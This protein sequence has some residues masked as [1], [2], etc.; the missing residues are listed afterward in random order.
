M[1][2][3]MSILM[4]SSPVPRASGIQSVERAMAALKLFGD[5]EP[6]LGVTELARRL[7]L[8]KSTTSRLMSTLETGGFVQQDRRSGRYR[9]GL[10][11]ATLA[12]RA[13]NQYDLRDVAR[14]ALTN[15]ATETGETCNL[16]VRDGDAAV[17]IEQALSPN[18]V[19]HLGWIG[20]RLP[21]HC[22]AAGKPF[23]AFASRN[24]TEHLLSRPLPAYTART[25]TDVGLMWQEIERIRTEGFA[26]AIEE[27]EPELT[28]AGA[29]VRDYRG[30]VIATV[31]VSGPSFRLNAERLREIA[32]K[33]RITADALSASL[34]YRTGTGPATL[35]TVQGKTAHARVVRR[36]VE[37]GPTSTERAD[38]IYASDVM[39]SDRRSNGIP[40]S[41]VVPAQV[42]P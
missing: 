27:F 26:L 3:G 15:L 22:S 24:E 4:D 31:T 28:A 12:S 13:L 7:S 1:R 39:R 11:L 17:N 41:D 8:H 36:S 6:E 29:P 2:N 35:A 9:L 18:P 16:A 19:K 40:S 5:D 30:D 38:S 37:V 10:Q 14:G 21:L 33:V 25:V 34:G 23:L 42:R 20:R 32:T